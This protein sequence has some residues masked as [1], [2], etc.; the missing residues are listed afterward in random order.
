MK[1]VLE[2]QSR[3]EIARNTLDNAI[4]QGRSFDDCYS[5][6]VELDELIEQFIMLQEEGAEANL[7]G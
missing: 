1:E 2:L 4:K 3:I 7:A 6:S 5:L